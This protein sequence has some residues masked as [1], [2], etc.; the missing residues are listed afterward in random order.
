MNKVAAAVLCAVITSGCGH[1]VAGTP[2]ATPQ[3]ALSAPEQRHLELEDALRAA[4]PCGLLDEGPLRDFGPILQYGSAVQLSVCSALMAGPRGG[5]TYVELSLLPSMLSGKSLTE[6][7]TVDGVTVY[8]G[9]GADLAR[10]TCERVFQ[11]E[12]GSLEVAPQLATVRAGTVAGEDVCP[13]VDAVL[14]S[15]IDAM[16]SGL[17]GRGSSSRQ[18]ALAS[19]DPCEVLGV[20]GDA[21]GGRVVDPA[22]APTPF[23]CV[24]FPTRRE[25]GT[26]VTVT[27]TLAPINGNRPRVQAD[28]EMVG[29]RCQWSTPVGEPID[30]TRPGAQVDEF[31]RKLGSAGAVV[32]VHGPNCTE[33][34]R[35]A[36]AA[37][38]V[39]G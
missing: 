19:H 1:S 22:A 23:D 10:G 8:G 33:V 34:A 5:T 16:A 26:E 38:T 11:L 9:A 2:A 37:T 32:T 39:F 6:P 15:A 17:P 29:D 4:D 25:P 35:V 21:A 18:V 20:L 14:V 27:F 3:K 36:E 31:T 12:L 24:L 30:V 28:P 7:D 13:L